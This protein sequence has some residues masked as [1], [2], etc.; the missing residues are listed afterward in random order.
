MNFFFFSFDS[1]LL[2][3]PKSFTYYRCCLK[4]SY[5]SDA[6]VSFNIKLYHIL[7]G[8]YVRVTQLRGQGSVRP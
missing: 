4:E 8:D 7:G 6:G 2:L 1:F 3:L 5:F